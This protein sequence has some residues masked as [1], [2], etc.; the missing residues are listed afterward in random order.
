MILNE[1]VDR[2]TQEM[3]TQLM[4]RQSLSYLGVPIMVG[5]TSLGVISVQST[6][7]EGIYDADDER[8]LST[9]AANVG[10]ALQNARLFREALAAQPRAPAWRLELGLPI[11]VRRGTGL[12]RRRGEP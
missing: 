4:G 12:D 10:V 7:M 2:R 9:I 3:G 5:G 1:D 8:L 11:A 6:H